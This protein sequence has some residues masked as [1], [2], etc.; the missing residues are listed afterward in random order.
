MVIVEIFLTL[1]KPLLPEPVQ[2]VS[3]AFFITGL[4][5]AVGAFGGLVWAAVI[6][7]M[8][9]VGLAAFY[10]KN[11]YAFDDMIVYVDK[12]GKP[13]GTAPKL[14]AHDGDT[15]LHSA[16]SVFVFNEKGE[17][18]LQQRAFSKKTWPGT[19][20]NSCCGHV[21]LHENVVDAAKRRLA[22]ELGL[23]VDKI[24][25]I[26]PNYRYRAEKDGIVENETCPVLV[27]F[28]STEPSPNPREVADIRW[29]PWPL[30]LENAANPANGYSPWAMEETRLLAE[31]PS[32]AEMR[33][34]FVVEST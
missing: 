17:L 4:W 9:I 24:E 25:I 34:R 10:Q 30:F 15:R 13:I 16:F 3:S 28:V 20:S 22:Y 2:I 12:A 31:S 7:V 26:L 18:L 14:A 33:A 19:W 29:E 32:F 27:G 1:R 11:Y 5:T 6:G 21:M 8:L 23:K